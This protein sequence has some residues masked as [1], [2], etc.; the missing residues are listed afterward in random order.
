[1]Q[2]PGSW[3]CRQESITI[4]L[5]ADK[6]RRH[7]LICTQSTSLLLCKDYILS[8]MIAMMSQPRSIPAAGALTRLFCLLELYYG[9]NL[10]VLLASAACWTAVRPAG[11]NSL[12]LY[13]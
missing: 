5:I 11:L 10:Q 13:V 2:V 6:L 9:A 7:A 12:S 3:Q 4:G 1:M 8:L